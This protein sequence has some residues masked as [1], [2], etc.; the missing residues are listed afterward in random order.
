MRA[1]GVMSHIMQGYQSTML[2]WARERPPCTQKSVHFTIGREGR[3]AQHVA[4]DDAC[5]GAGDVRNP[6]WALYDG[7]NPNRCLVQIEHEGFSVPPSHGY[8]FAYDTDGV[9]W[10][11]P[12]VEASIRVH[13][14]VFEQLG[15]T[16]S[17]DTVIGHFETNSVDRAHDPGS[18]WPRDRIIV[19]LQ[20]HRV[21]A[22]SPPFGKDDAIPLFFL[23]YGYPSA[24]PVVEVI[25]EPRAPDERRV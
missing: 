24:A 15:L 11:E 14:R 18:S 1:R 13:R 16:P 23:A 2:E 19:T 6:S 10:P 8:D 4:I 5:W 20:S 25:P 7:T 12:M 9:S 22:V 21:G 17:R 3:I